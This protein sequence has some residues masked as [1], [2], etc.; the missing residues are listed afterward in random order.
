LEVYPDD[1]IEIPSG[2]TPGPDPDP[3]PDPEPEQ[4][5]AATRVWTHSGGPGDA[6]LYMQ[7]GTYENGVFVPSGETIDVL[8]TN[9][10]NWV[11]H[12][13]VQVRYEQ[14]WSVR[15]VVSVDFNGTSYPAEQVITSWRY[16]TGVDYLFI[17]A[18][19]DTDSFDLL[20]WEY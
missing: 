15:G 11:E 18:A 7:T 8:Y 20:L 12:G 5:P 6:S 3:G 1:T 16:N 13:I 4:A 2:S 9:A 19:S 17:E 10:S 14:Q